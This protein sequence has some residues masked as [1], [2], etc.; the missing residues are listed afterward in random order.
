MTS[1]SLGRQ[2]R[3]AQRSSAP[4]QSRT[5]IVIG[6]SDQHLMDEF[7]GASDGC[8]EPWEIAQYFSVPEEMVRLQPELL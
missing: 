5:R 3:K 2:Q 7:V 6:V 8:V 1:P 4:Y